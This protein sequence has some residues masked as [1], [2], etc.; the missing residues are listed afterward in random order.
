MLENE[1]VVPSP[2]QLD[3][4]GVSARRRA[5]PGARSPIADHQLPVH[6]QPPAAL[7]FDL[8]SVDLRKLRQHLGGETRDEIVRV[9]PGAR[10]RRAPGVV[11]ICVDARQHGRRRVQ[12]DRAAGVRE[13][14]D[15]HIG[16]V[17]KTRLHACASGR[18]RVV[19]EHR[20]RCRCAHRVARRRAD[21]Q[22]RR[23]GRFERRVGQRRDRHRR[24]IHPERQRHR[25]RDRRVI[26]TRHRR[27]AHRVVHR[28]RIQ[29][30]GP[31]DLES[32]RVQ[33]RPGQRLGRARVRRRHRHH[34]HRAQRLRDGRQ[35]V[36]PAQPVAVRIFRV[37]AERDFLPV[38]HPV[39]VAVHI[40]HRHAV[41][42]LR[43]PGRRDRDHEI[44]AIAH[45]Q[46]VRHRPH[47]R[48]QARGFLQH[49][50][51]A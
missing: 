29:I 32:P 35:I 28:D 8:E 3:S 48:G 25:A 21:R 33:R 22:D 19:D 49:V 38:V 30:A 7:H 40:L 11:D 42:I 14:R 12:I 10:R 45:D 16:I 17:P 51:F 6:P 18:L 27:A 1:R 47:R 46:R 15:R 41:E 50:A 4:A 36:R 23:L 31:L 9:H 44:A 26:R 2:H 43:R 5:D 34:I 37:K 13:N 24:R 20:C 39:A